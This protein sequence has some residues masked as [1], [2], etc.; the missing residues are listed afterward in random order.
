MDRRRKTGTHE[1]ESAEVVRMKVEKIEFNKAGF[2][3]ILN[4]PGVE[5]L[6]RQ[7][8]EEVRERANANLHTE[9]EGFMSK[10]YTGAGQGR[11]VG[12]VG[13]TDYASMVAEAE[14][15]ALSRSVR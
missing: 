13:T 5:S 7:K 14:E 15:K 8:T 4:S 10:I 9:S 12:I 1:T 11:V 3:G 2:R 6:I